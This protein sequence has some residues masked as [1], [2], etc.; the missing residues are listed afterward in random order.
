[1]ERR[2][3]NGRSLGTLATVFVVLSDAVAGMMI[4]YLFLK[5]DA[6][7]TQAALPVSLTVFAQQEIDDLWRSLLFNLTTDVELRRTASALE[8]QPRMDDWC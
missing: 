2:V 7:L 3:W 5:S 4:L 8:W 6:F 1:M